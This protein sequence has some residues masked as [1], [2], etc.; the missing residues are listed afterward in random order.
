MRSAE[1]SDY[2]SSQCPDECI[3]SEYE[4]DV[5]VEASSDGHLGVVEGTHE[6]QRWPIYEAKSVRLD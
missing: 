5:L 2:G 6:F 1:D 4:G 3:D